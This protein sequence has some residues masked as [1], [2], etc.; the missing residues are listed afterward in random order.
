MRV[1][2][3]GAKG[4]VGQTAVHALQDRNEI[5][6]VGRSHGDIRVDV[7]DVES[8]RAMYEQAGKVDAVVIAIGHGHFGNVA[9]MT[10][11]LWMKGILHKVLPQVNVVL[12]GIQ[13]VNDN[14]SFTMTTGVLN[15]DPIAGGASAAAANGAIDSFVFGASVDMPRGIRINSVSPGVLQNSMDRYE[16]LFPGHEPVSSERVGLAYVKCVEGVITGQTVIVD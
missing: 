9:D 11:E 14:G 8:I 13:H 1:L 7:E 16:G 3:I 2:V 15:R 12:E 5:I 4:S 6:A 10:G